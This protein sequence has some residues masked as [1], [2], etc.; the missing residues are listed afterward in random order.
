MQTDLVQKQERGGQE[1]ASTHAYM[2]FLMSDSSEV[3][4]IRMIR[5]NGEEKARARRQGI[6]ILANFAMW[7]HHMMMRHRRIHPT[8]TLVSAAH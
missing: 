6:V 5:E 7:I 3:E 2:M 4:E 1:A 8:S